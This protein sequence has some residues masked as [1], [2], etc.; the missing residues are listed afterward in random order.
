[1]KKRNLKQLSEAELVADFRECALETVEAKLDSNRRRITRLFHRFHTIQ[2]E[3]IERGPEARRALLTLLDDPHLRV[4]Y[5]AARR[6]LALDKDRALGVI[7]E[8]V[9]SRKMP[10]AGEAG[11]TLLALE[12][13][14]FKPT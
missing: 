1:M 7:N 4:R 2:A 12:Q 6:C 3:L 5:E 11:M 9:R 13:G 8:V 14:I 10:E